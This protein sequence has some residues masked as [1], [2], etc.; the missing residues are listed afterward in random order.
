MAFPNTPILDN[1][2]RADGA[3]G[4][5]WTPGVEAGLS[6]PVLFSN[7][8][9]GVV[10][11][12]NTAY[13]NATQFPPDQEAYFTIPL[14]ATT[15]DFTAIYLR[16]NNPGASVD[17]YSASWKSGGAPELEIFRS[18]NGA[19]SSTLA[20][21]TVGNPFAGLKWGASVKSVGANA[22]IEVYA[23]LGNG[24]SST[25][26]LTYTDVAANADLMVAGYIGF[27]VYGSGV[28]ATTRQIDNFGG[29][30]LALPAAQVVKV[31]DF[32]VYPKHVLRS[33]R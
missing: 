21:A 22:V 23:D 30:D 15:I 2:T 7:A 1:F 16:I 10:S 25:P 3:L 14:T 13:W 28:A 5:N 29:G 20:S 8:V 6:T 11:A 9:S 17:C 31:P 4:A 18:I 12:Y 24:W 27:V 32:K 33:V 26:I 19:G